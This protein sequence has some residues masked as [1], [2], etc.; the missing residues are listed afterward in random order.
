VKPYYEDESTQIWHG[1]CRDVL[2]LLSN[3]QTTVTSPPYN[4]LG[5]RV[6]QNGTG[7]MK[8]NSWLAKTNEHGY[9]DDM[10]EEEYQAQQ[11]EIA[12]LIWNVTVPGGSF[13]YNHKVRY[14]DYEMLHPVALAATFTGWQM[15]QEIVWDRA[16]A[17]AFNAR[18]FAPSDERVIWMWRPDAPHI[19]NQE[20]AKW[21][22]AWRISPLLADG[23]DHPCPFPNEIPKRCI[24]ATT[25]PGD[26]VL[27]PFLGSG[28]TL[29][30]AKDLGRR[31]I[32]IESEERFCEMAVARLAQGVFAL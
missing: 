23:G 16:Q 7:L 30:V 8:G 22:S 10:S 12:G 26:I 6:P 2:P 14:R 17:I 13:F 31:G 25:Q 4:T 11:K 27:D 3:I 19:W 21:M 28:T 20:A 15:R 18:M 9:A 24:I 32:G 29:R 1:D 5:G